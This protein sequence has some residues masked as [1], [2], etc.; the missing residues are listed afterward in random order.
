MR[1]LREKVGE[2]RRVMFVISFV[3]GRAMVAGHKTAAHEII[4]ARR[5]RQRDRRL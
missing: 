4:A 1:K 5:R 3:N 2:K